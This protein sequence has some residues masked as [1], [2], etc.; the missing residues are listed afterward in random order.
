MNEYVVRRG[1]EIKFSGMTF[2]F[3]WTEEIVGIIFSL[4]NMSEILNGWSYIFL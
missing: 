1:S 3:I 2:W 4:L